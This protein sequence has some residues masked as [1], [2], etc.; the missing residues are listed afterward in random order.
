MDEY[1]KNLKEELIKLKKDN[2]YIE[3]CSAYAQALLDHG[4]P[5]FFDA[6]HVNLFLKMEGIKRNGYHYFNAGN[7]HKQRIIE[8]PSVNLKGKSGLPII[9]SAMKFLATGFMDTLR[10]NRSLRMP[11]FMREK[12][13]FYIWI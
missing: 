4:K 9:F 6:A 10:E 3:K 11:G 1:I 8:A 2:E 13:V 7:R 5:V 12:T